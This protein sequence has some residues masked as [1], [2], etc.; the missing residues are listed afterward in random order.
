MLNDFLKISQVDANFIIT[1]LVRSVVGGKE[2]SEVYRPSGTVVRFATIDSG[3][4]YASVES[5]NED[6]LKGDSDEKE[7]ALN[8]IDNTQ[9]AT[10]KGNGYNPATTEGATSLNNYYGQDCEGEML[11]GDVFM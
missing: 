1:F 8:A 9:S 10:L 3:D 2:E 7:F 6:D 11:E 4:D 5:G